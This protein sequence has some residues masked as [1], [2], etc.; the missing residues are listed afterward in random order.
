MLAKL[1]V[2]FVVYIGFKYFIIFSD[3]A[4]IISNAVMRI[5]TVDLE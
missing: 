5:F 3:L 2:Y 1:T 4:F